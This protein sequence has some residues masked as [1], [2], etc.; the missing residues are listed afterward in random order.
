[1]HPLG[2][3]WYHGRTPPGCSAISEVIIGRVLCLRFSPDGNVL[4]SGFW[5]VRLWDVDTSRCERILEFHDE[6]VRSLAF[7]PDGVLLAVGEAD[8]AY[9]WRLEWSRHYL[10]RPSV[11]VRG[12]GRISI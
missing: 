8:G 10:P 9:E 1:M 3:Q 6:A 4:A 7:S 12:C 11:D 2:R 5:D